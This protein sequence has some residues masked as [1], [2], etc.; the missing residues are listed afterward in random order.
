MHL[1]LDP[2]GLQRAKDRDL[3]FYRTACGDIVPVAELTLDVRAVTCGLCQRAIA[4]SQGASGPPP[5][6]SMSGPDADGGLLEVDFE[7]DDDLQVDVDLSGF[8][9]PQ[10][11]TAD[12]D[13]EDDTD[14]EAMD[15]SAM[16]GMV[17]TMVQQWTSDVVL[18]DGY[19]ALTE[20]AT[21]A[22]DVLTEAEANA[23]FNLYQILETVDMNDLANPLVSIIYRLVLKVRDA[24][25]AAE[26]SDV[27]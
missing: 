1:A 26:E 3:P 15:M 5:G 7:D 27:E 4:A 14:D 25:G 24:Q 19:A 21:S 17:R 22:T 16:A 6:V 18:V 23:V 13:D 20:D 2:D 9:M 12:E 8:D 10:T 11:D